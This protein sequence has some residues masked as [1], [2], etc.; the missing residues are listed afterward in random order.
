[1]HT[2]LRNSWAC[3]TT[4]SVLGHLHQGGEGRLCTIC[5]I[6]CNCSSLNLF[7]T[8][9]PS[10]QRNASLEQVV[11]QPQHGVQ[12]QVVGGLVQQQE[13]YRAGRGPVQAASKGTPQVVASNSR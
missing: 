2:V 11:L 9:I 8:C 5:F 1:M 7:G 6:L 4:I 12:V 13:V 3:D 10:V